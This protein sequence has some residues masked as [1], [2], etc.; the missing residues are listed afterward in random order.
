[1]INNIHI[2]SRAMVGRKGFEPPQPITI[3]D[4][5]SSASQPIAPPPHDLMYK[6][7]LWIKPEITF[8]SKFLWT[9]RESNPPLSPC[10][11]ETPAL[12]HASPN[13]VT[14]SGVEPETPK[15]KVSCSTQLSYEV[16]PISNQLVVGRNGFEPLTPS[17]HWISK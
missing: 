3:L 6:L 10:K 5:K 4:P 8:I 12:V 16:D 9:R 11:G 7:Y 14:P 2:L 15:L 17:F 1:M 13:L